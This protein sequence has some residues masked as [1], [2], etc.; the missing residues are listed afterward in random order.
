MLIIFLPSVLFEEVVTLSSD[1]QFVSRL[2]PRRLCL[3]NSSV[4][5]AV[6]VFYTVKMYDNSDSTL[7]VHCSTMLLVLLAIGQLAHD[8]NLGRVGNTL[9]SSSSSFKPRHRLQKAPMSR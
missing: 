4:A 8:N 9:T 6:D 3:V 5:E 7:Y 1:Q 2:L